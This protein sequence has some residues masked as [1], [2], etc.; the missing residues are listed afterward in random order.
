MQKKKK[1]K[2]KAQKAFLYRAGF[3]FMQNSVREGKF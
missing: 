2:S 3:S 1:K